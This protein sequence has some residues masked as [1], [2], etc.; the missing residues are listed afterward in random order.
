MPVHCLLHLSTPWY[1]IPR[2]PPSLIHH[3]WTEVD[4]WGTGDIQICMYALS[5]W[6]VLPVKMGG[7][8]KL[9]SQTV[10]EC[11]KGWSFA[12]GSLPPTSSSCPPDDIHVMNE[13]RPSPF[14]TLLLSCNMETEEQ[15][16]KAWEWGYTWCVGQCTF[17]YPTFWSCWRYTMCL[18][19]SSFVETATSG[20]CGKVPVLSFVETIIATCCLGNGLYYMATTWSLSWYGNVTDCCW[21]DQITPFL[22]HISCDQFF[23]LTTY[24]WI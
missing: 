4:K 21:Q 2:P 13:T 10:V 20:P 1:H 19:I 18:L 6:S 12:V 22:T 3:V 15:K 16:L 11:L 23:F 5:F 9:T 17:T 24:K 7:L 14:F 8:I